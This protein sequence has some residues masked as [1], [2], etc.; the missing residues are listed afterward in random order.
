MAFAQKLINVRFSLATG[1]FQGG[2]NTADLTGL[3]I[4]ARIDGPGGMEGM[5]AS[6][7]IWGMPLQMMNQLSL[8]GQQFMAVTPQNTIS[9]TAGDTP[10]SL[11]LVYSGTIITAC[12][13]AGQMPNVC[14]RVESSLSSALNTIPVD[15][16]GFDPIDVA[17]YMQSLASQSTPKLDFENNGVNLKIPKVYL[18]GSVYT[19]I[20]SLARQAG[21]E[22]IIDRGKL[23]IWMLGQG[24]TGATIE[25]P[26]M[27]GYPSFS[28]A[29]V[30]VKTLFDPTIRNGQIITIK[31]EL[32]AACGR[33][34]VYHV[35]HEIESQIPKGKWF[36]TIGAMP[37]TPA[38]QSAP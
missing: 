12:V 38:S 11:P 2:G 26:N 35:T 1:Q 27:I 9:I 20:R 22:Y 23:S 32:T 18:D 14:F 10:S 28:Q 33:W 7:A 16:Q 37:I 13:D 31:S 24:P 4:S 21:I 5:T 29:Y 6:V 30:Y 3:R 34:Q 17:Q 8:V 25:P 15:A 36:T 19:Q